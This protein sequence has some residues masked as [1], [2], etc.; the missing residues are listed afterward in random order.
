MLYYYSMNRS[1]Q[2]LS[3]D[4]LWIDDW[5]QLVLT[6]I[7][8]PKH[9]TGLIGVYEV[10]EITEAEIAHLR[11]QK[12]VPMPKLAYI[13]GPWIIV[14]SECDAYIAKGMGWKPLMKWNRDD[15]FTFATEEAAKSEIAQTY[16]RIAKTMQLD[17]REFRDGKRPS[18]NDTLDFV[19]KYGMDHA[20]IN[21]LLSGAKT[22]APSKR[23]AFFAEYAALTEKYKIR[24]FSPNCRYNHDGDQLEVY[25]TD[26]F[27]FCDPAGPASPGI[28]IMRSMA[29]QAITGVKIQ[30]FLNRLCG[31]DPSR[32][33]MIMD[34]EM[35]NIIC[36]WYEE[37]IKNNGPAWTWKPEELEFFHAVHRA[38]PGM[39]FAFLEDL[40]RV[41]HS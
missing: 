5:S 15:A 39:K 35:V 8:L 32:Q 23:E 10:Y 17:F 41:T 26:D 16:T 21:E 29:T 13:P 38:W 24:P 19:L 36:E 12:R 40:P 31:A 33:A 9:D 30:G 25:L 37:R 11:G 28:L 6:T 14:S 20:H 4:M 22:I 18:I 34:I 7:T 2:Y 3:R 1:G 27:S